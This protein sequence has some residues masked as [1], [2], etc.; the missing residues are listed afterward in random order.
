M[1]ELRSAMEAHRTC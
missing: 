1:S